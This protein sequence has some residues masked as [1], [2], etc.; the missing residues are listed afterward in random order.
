MFHWVLREQNYSFEDAA[1]VYY[2]LTDLQLLWLSEVLRKERAQVDNKSKLK[3][4]RSRVFRKR[5][6]T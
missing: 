4:I 1:K 3:D 5:M 6:Y 2:S